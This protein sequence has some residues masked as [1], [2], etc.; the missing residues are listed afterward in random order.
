MTAYQEDAGDKAAP[1]KARQTMLAPLRKHPLPYLALGAGA[2]GGFYAVYR[3]RHRFQQDDDFKRGTKYRGRQCTGTQHASP[4]HEQSPAAE[5]HDRATG[6][7]VPKNTK[8]IGSEPLHTG[9]GEEFRDDQYG[10]GWDGIRGPSFARTKNRL[11]QDRDALTKKYATAF[12]LTP[13]RFGIISAI[14]GGILGALLP[15]S[16][17]ERNL[18]RPLGQRFWLQAQHWSAQE[19]Q[20]WD[21]AIDAQVESPAPD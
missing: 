16:L 13:L 12:R 17:R 14:V 7:R 20:K 9:N 10:Q 11:K 5:R 2:L 15:L 4:T 3:R 1:G 8:N 21:A 19:L 6:E 18:W